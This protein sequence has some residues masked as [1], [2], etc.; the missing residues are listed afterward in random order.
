[1]KIKD[2]FYN[3]AVGFV[4][5]LGQREEY[6]NEGLLPISS[7]N[8]SFL[9]KIQTAIG[10]IVDLQ[11]EAEQFLPS[12]PVLLAEDC[13][14]YKEARNNNLLKQNW[15][16]GVVYFTALGDPNIKVPMNA[17]YY[18]LTT[19]GSMCLL[20]LAKKRPVRGGIDISWGVE[21][22][23]GEIYGSAV[24]KA[25]QIESSIAQYPRIV[26]GPYL[27]DYLKRS[28]A[29][30]PNTRFDECNRDI[31]QFC[32]NFLLEDVDG[33]QIIHYLG[34]FYRQKLPADH[35]R[36]YWKA[37]AFINEQLAAHKNTYNT[38]LAF[39]YALLQRYFLEYPP[40]EAEVR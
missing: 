12:S 10:S 16:D 6:A 26:L 24:A 37:M 36:L 17:V 5:I 23:P 27:R 9:N 25:Y 28:A 34:D 18:L 38:K 3:Y 1:V 14:E 20:G 40:K 33:Q 13:E 15:S 19:L 22:R 35:S 4:D 11:R 7:D 31:A 2:T 21:L 32:L 39:R 29:E 8:T 30:T